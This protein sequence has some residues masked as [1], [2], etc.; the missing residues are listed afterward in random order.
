MNELIELEAIKRLKYK[1]LRCLDLKRWADLA[2]CFTAD[3]T[4]AY[5]GGKYSFEGR[6]A[7]MDFLEKAR[8]TTS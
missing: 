5:G 1:Y 7:I 8:C 2:E 3:A 6:D 4:S